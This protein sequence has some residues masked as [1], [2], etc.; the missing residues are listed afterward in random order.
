MLYLAQI[1]LRFFVTETGLVELF[2]A[3]EELVFE[4]GTFQ[5]FAE[6]KGGPLG[7]GPGDFPDIGGVF[8]DGELVIVQT[9][10][11]IVK[12]PVPHTAGLLPATHIVDRPVPVGGKKFENEVIDDV[13]NVNSLGEMVILN[14]IGKVRRCQRVVK[15][16]KIVRR[17]ALQRSPCGN[18]VDTVGIDA[19]M[20]FQV[21]LVNLLLNEI[22]APVFA[23][24]EESGRSGSCDSHLERG[25]Y[26]V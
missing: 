2:Q 12:H 14:R 3:D 23:V 25:R 13:G 22:D 20:A 21:T 18:D 10:I 7:G 17:A 4:G 26:L 16:E 5:Q 8:V 6:E 9:A 1:G 19:V 11:P 15:V 24:E